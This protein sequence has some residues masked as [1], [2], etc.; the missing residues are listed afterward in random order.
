M[1]YWGASAML[2]QRADK[3][4]SSMRTRQA[5][6]TLMFMAATLLC[7]SGPANALTP[8]PNNWKFNLQP[9]VSFAGMSVG[10]ASGATGGYDG[11][12]PKDLTGKTGAAFLLRRTNGEAG[13]T[14]P[15]GWYGHEYVA[16][17]TPGSSHTFANIYLWAQNRTP[18]SN[19]AGVG[20]SSDPELPVP[21]GYRGHLV[22]DYVPTSL[23]YT[24]PMDFEFSLGSPPGRMDLPLPT[25]A[26]P[27]DGVRMHL[28]VTAPA[29]P[30]PSSLAALGLGLLPLGGAVLRRRSRRE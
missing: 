14:G 19:P 10:V 6:A 7:T 24:G 17:L 3:R 28:T 12:T 15:T 23:N 8:D 18:S 16:P 1:R 11:Q 27:L 20:L 13:W 26:D 5:L 4:E 21:T 29:V 9:L 25:V 30:E 2:T 22:L